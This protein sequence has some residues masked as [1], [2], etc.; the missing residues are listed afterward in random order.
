MKALLFS[1]LHGGR[2]FLN[3]LPNLIK[4]FDLI[5]FAGDITDFGWPEGFAYQVD[6]VFEDKTCFWVSG[7]NDISQ[8]YQ[9][10][11]KNMQNIDGK[12][13][14]YQGYKFAGLGGSYQNYEAQNFGPSLIDK[15][16][17]L[18]NCIL[19]SHIPPS[20]KLNFSS[21]DI[22]CPMGESKL[23]KAPLV[24]I[25]GHL[26]TTAAVACLGSTKV[27]RLAPAKQGCYAELDLENLNI[28]FKDI[29]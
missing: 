7:N 13:V 18:S 23:K 27:I 12:I 3:Q 19:L 4:G 24:H 28:K 14:K 5:L 11:L 6:E 25:C 1:D 16:A 8:E 2:E 10:R 17:D 29:K 20:V 9:Y 15:D 26:H 22:V 21:T